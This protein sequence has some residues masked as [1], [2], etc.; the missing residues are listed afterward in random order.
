MLVPSVFV[1]LSGALGK[2]IY[3]ILLAFMLYTVLSDTDEFVI[4][5]T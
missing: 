5:V 2:H 1:I 3:N 4:E